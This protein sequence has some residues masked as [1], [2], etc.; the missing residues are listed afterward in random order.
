MRL[1]F[2]NAV[3]NLV[4]LAPIVLAT[5]AFAAEPKP[6][7]TGLWS[8]TVPGRNGGADRVSKLKLKSDGTHLTGTLSSPGRDGQ[9][10]DIQIADGKVDG[11]NLSFLVVRTIQG[12]PSTNRF[13]GKL[14]TDRIS[15]TT[16]FE[17]N[18]EKQSRPWEA[19]RTPDAK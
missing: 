3:R 19:K 15:G 13:S 4:T 9:P 10:T 18:G 2:L 1:P 7:P 6:D 17:R 11:E 12:N 5:A 16:E 8:W 14:T